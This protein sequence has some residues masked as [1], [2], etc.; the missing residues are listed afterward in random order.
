MEW[1]D[2]GIV[3]STR[4]HGE[5]GVIAEVL[6]REHG[7]HLG[8]VRGG[9]GR[10]LRAALQAGNSLQVTWRARLSEHLGAYTVEVETSRAAAL[11][12]G[13]AAL[14]G[15]NTA[16]ALAHLLAERES[17]RGLH[18]ALEVVLEAMVAGNDWAPLLVRWE[19]GLLEELGFGIDLSACAATGAP[20]DLAYVSPKSAKAVSRA[21]GAAYSNRL[22]PL[23]GFLAGARGPVDMI[24]VVDGFRLTGFFLDRHVMRPRGIA[25]PPA[26]ERMVRALQREG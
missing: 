1:T 9:A 24:E 5:A 14:A 8:M 7:R 23:P 3:V 20:D 17:A 10:R 16:C 4:R 21:A 19:L 22:L 12:E 6:T 18:D 11:M 26:R 25:M 13:K 2:R 15:L